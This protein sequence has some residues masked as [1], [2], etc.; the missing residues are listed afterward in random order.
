MTSFSTYAKNKMLDLYN[1]HTHEVGSQ[2]KKNN[3]Q[4]YESLEATDC[5][6]YV[7]KVLSH[8]YKKIGNV[9]LSKEIWLMGREN[10][11]SNFRGTILAKKL[12]SNYGWS[13]IFAT[14]DS[15]HPEDGDE[16]HTYATVMAKRRCVYSPDQVPV[17]YLVADYSPTTESHPEFQKLYPNL[18]ARKLK[19]LDYKELKKIPFAFGLSRGG[20]HCWLFSEGYVYEVHW[21]KV[22]KGLYSKVPLK[23][24]DW[25]SSLIVVPADTENKY[26][27]KT[28]NCWG[29]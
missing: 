17:K 25:L 4:K 18:P 29:R 7:L 24:F 11:Q 23:Q 14:P 19:T 8:S 2:L 28:L 21:D 22:G 12:V 10:M 26:K 20:T 13:S 15:I 3:P 27:L 5:I 9:Q 16:E 1:N 6:T